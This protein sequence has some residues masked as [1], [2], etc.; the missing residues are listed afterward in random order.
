MNLLLSEKEFGRNRFWPAKLQFLTLLP[1]GFYSS[2]AFFLRR[3]TM[4][5]RNTAISAPHTKR[6]ME[7]SI[8]SLLS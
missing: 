5:P 3:N 8:D 6:T 2:A 4:I 1:G 7:V